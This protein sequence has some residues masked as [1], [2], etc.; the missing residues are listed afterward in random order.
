MQK[1][2]LNLTYSFPVNRVGSV[3]SNT[4]AILISG[5]RLAFINNTDT[6]PTIAVV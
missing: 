1:Q 6:N 3:G 2:N 4:T 5:D